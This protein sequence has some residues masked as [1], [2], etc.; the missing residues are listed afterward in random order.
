MKLI[1]HIPCYNEEDTIGYTLSQLPRQI[2][3]FNKVEWIITD[4]GSTDNTIEEARKHGIDHILHLSKNKGLAKAFMAGINRCLDLGAD[5]IV[6][7]D[8][9]NQYNADDIESLVRPILDEDAELVVGRRPIDQIEHFSTIK[10]KLQRIGSWVVRKVSRTEIPDAASG[11][12]AFS[13]SAAMQ[14]NVFNEYTYTLEMIIQA[15]QKGMSIQSVPVRVNDDLRPSR[16]VKSNSS[17]I[18]RSIMTIIR[19]FVVYKPFSFFMTLGVTAFGIG[20]LIGVRFL[21]FFFT[22]G[23]EG[24]IQS[25][26]LASILLSMGFQTILVA[27]LA[28]LMA[29][30]RKLSEEIQHKLRQEHNR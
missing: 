27:F 22:E 9:D 18:F 19:I 25:L 20:F 6:N 28:D 8:A 3:G 4:D 1:I 2:D 26:I 17:Y 10:K 16:L 11:F 13:R 7:T 29:V 12:R 5:V 24:H 21:F 14:F 15:G 23:G 30:N